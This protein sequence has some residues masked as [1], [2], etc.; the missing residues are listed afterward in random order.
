MSD[1]TDSVNVEKYQLIE[2]I[3]K[4]GSGVVYLAQ[5]TRLKR[6]VALKQ[7]MLKGVA[8]PA[9]VIDRFY[10]EAQ[11]TARFQHL[12]IMQIYDVFESAGQHYI[13][14]ELLDRRTLGD[15][16][17]SPDT[18]LEGLL[19]V[20]IEAAEGL[21][22]AHRQGVIHRDIKPDNI[23]V[24]FKGQAKLMDFGV[25]KRQDLDTDT[26]DGSILG[27]IGYMSPE[28][29]INSK[30]ADVCGD[31]YSFGAMVYHLLTGELPF[32]GEGLADT[33]RRIFQDSLRL[34]HTLAPG[35]PPAL[36]AVIAQA[37]CREPEQRYASMLILQSDLKR[38]KALLSPEQLALPLSAMLQPAEAAEAAPAGQPFTEFGLTEVILA[39]LE[40]SFD[41]WLE[42]KREGG[43]S[44]R[45]GFC[46][47]AITAIELPSRAIESA[48]D[49]L[50]EL[51][52]WEQGHYQLVTAA[53]PIL[54]PATQALFQHIPTDL[55]LMDLFDC[56]MSYCKL[57]AHFADK[58]AYHPNGLVEHASQSVVHSPNLKRVLAHSDGKR[59]LAD[60]LDLLP[61]DR[62]SVLRALDELFRRGLLLLD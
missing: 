39:Q 14:M 24:T 2:C 23:I 9:P 47:G 46:Q 20:L 41:G 16:V 55:L 5:D 21:D 29:L 37:L 13:A 22:Y 48:L 45:V 8:D 56:R 60:L 12:N 57:H 4:G 50:Y 59:S 33:I 53:A 30:S 35:I 19:D 42:V 49:R 61:L 62:L 52:C 10:R 6:E 17:R 15:F 31:V 43:V 51:I 27:T 18:T 1:V 38:V 34:P 58:F 25:A 32:A 7:L 11:T 40:Q 36:S 28:Q 3:G 54:D 44:G 26:I